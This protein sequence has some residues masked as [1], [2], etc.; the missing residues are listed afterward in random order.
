MK[1]RYQV[2]STGKTT[3]RSRTTNQELEGQKWVKETRKRDWNGDRW[4]MAPYECTGTSHKRT[5]G[6]VDQDSQNS[7]ALPGHTGQKLL[8]LLLISARCHL[9][10]QA[11]RL[12]SALSY[13]GN[14]PLSPQTTHRTEVGLLPPGTAAPRQHR[15]DIAAA[16]RTLYHRFTKYTSSHTTWLHK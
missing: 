12:C 10:C 4:W 14:L 3:V 7:W 9:C 16:D 11:P 2:W 6:G 13:C 8:K 1:K 15:A 5:A